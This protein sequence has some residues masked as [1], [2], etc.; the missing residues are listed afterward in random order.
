MIYFYAYDSK[1]FLGLVQIPKGKVS[2]YKEIAQAILKER[3]EQGGVQGRLCQAVGN[4]L[5]R[6]PFPKH[7]VPCHRVIPSS[8]IIT[9]YHGK[10]TLE[11]ITE[12]LNILQCEG[13]DLFE[14]QSVKS[15]QQRLELLKI[16]ITRFV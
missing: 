16:Y 10:R 13:V 3:G 12:R 7:L 5:A 8:G 9:G 14:L 1:Q 15:G 2:T 11:A 6:N 4:S